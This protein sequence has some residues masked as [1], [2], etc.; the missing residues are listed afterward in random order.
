MKNSK[1]MYMV[2]DFSDLHKCIFVK[3]EEA[4]MFENICSETNKIKYSKRE[5][6]VIINS[7]KRH[8][9]GSKKKVPRRCYACSSCGTFHITHMPFLK[10]VREYLKYKAS[11]Y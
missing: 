7:Y 10:G 2:A 6:G 4:M 3:G 11:D 5:A 8:H 9:H 1:K